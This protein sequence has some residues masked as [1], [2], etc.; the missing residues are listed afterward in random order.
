MFLTVIRPLLLLEGHPG[1]PVTLHMPFS[2]TSVGG[3]FNDDYNHYY[4]M[5]DSEKKVATHNDKNASTNDNHERVTKATFQVWSRALV[6]LEECVR[7]Y[8]I[9]TGLNEIEQD[10]A[11]GLVVVTTERLVGVDM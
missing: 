5:A 7:D 1:P 3:I 6:A 9:Q 10:M 8:E 2:H 4:F 11:Q